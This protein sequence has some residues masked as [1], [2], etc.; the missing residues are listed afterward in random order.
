MVS[1]RTSDIARDWKANEYYDRAEQEDWT[2]V[3]WKAGSDFRRL[4]DQLDTNVT[5]ELACGTVAILPVC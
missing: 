1:S 2:D 3:F 4:F 5:V